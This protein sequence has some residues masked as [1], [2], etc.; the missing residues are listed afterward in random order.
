M[1]FKVKIIPTQ[2][3]QSMCR[4]RPGVSHFKE[5]AHLR[6]ELKE[7]EFVLRTF[8]EVEKAKYQDGDLIHIKCM[9]NH[10]EIGSIKRVVKEGPQFLK[11]TPLNRL[12]IRNIRDK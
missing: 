12:L 4:V 7:D 2:V 1:N 3:Y 11:W 8:C 10:V 9:F 6:M 5:L